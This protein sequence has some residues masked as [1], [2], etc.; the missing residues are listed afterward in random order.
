M[1]IPAVKTLLSDSAFHDSAA[2]SC[3]RLAADRLHQHCL[4][5]L[6]SRTAAKPQPPAN[7]SRDAKLDCKC[8][9]CCELAAFLKNKDES[10]H[11]FARR[12]E[13]R[14]HLHQQIDKH[15]CDVTHATDR[16]GSPQTLV[17]TKTQTSYERQ[18]AQFET[19]LRLLGELECLSTPSSVPGV[20]KKVRRRT[21]KT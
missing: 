2:S 3:G 6:R 10:V 12:K 5:E 8:A 19:D 1:L 18:L 4:A 17:C 13:L 9:D 16:R 14:Q 11:R 20:A 7:W 21:K 15:R